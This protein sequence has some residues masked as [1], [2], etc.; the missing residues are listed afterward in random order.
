MRDLRRQRLQLG[1][2][3]L[4][5]QVLDRLVAEIGVRSCGAARSGGG[6]GATLPPSYTAAPAGTKTRKMRRIGSRPPGGAPFGQR[7]AAGR[8]ARRPTRSRLRGDDSKGLMFNP[9]K[10]GGHRPRRA[11]PPP[12]PAPPPIML[13]SSIARAFPG[14]SS[15]PRFNPQ[16]LAAPPPRRATSGASAPPARPVQRPRPPCGDDSKGLMFN[17]KHRGPCPRGP[18]GISRARALPPP[19]ALSEHGSPGIRSCQS[20]LT[21]RSRGSSRRGSTSVIRFSVAWRPP[22]PGEAGPS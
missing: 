1:G 6:G 5:G 15:V 21:L 19:S 2:R 14:G 3:L 10:P 17:P 12:A 13:L 16:R 22:G 20:G 8:D 11:G 4:L 18:T 9:K 7:A